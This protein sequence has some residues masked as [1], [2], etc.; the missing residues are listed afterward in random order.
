MVRTAIL[1]VIPAVV[2][3]LRETT[4]RDES[5]STVKKKSQCVLH[6]LCNQKPFKKKQ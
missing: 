5:Y 3:K 2:P 1:M 6:K 4:H